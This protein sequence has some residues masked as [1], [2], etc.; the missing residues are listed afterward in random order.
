[1]LDYH[2]AYLY[3]FFVHKQEKEDKMKHYPCER[4]GTRNRPSRHHLLPK[5]WWNGRGQI[6]HLCIPCHRLVEDIILTA[7]TENSH[8]RVKLDEN[9][10]VDIYYRFIQT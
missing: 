10:Y 9:Q 1:M 6:G 8:E 2:T 3:H 4:C 7:E 5:R